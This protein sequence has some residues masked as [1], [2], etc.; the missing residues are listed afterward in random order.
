MY[1]LL[2]VPCAINVNVWYNGK[3][4]IDESIVE[5][6]SCGHRILP[7]IHKMKHSVDKRLG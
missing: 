1:T 5:A 2:P 7:D 4:S 3:V 6:W